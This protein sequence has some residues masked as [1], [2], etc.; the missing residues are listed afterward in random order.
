M[1]GSWLLATSGGM[2]LKFDL[3]KAERVFVVGG[4]KPTAAM[5]LAVEQII[6]HRITDGVISIRE[7]FSVPLQKAR[8]IEASHPPPTNAALL[9]LGISRISSARRVNAI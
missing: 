7:G 5:A 1:D 9:R 8:I 4:G 6:A 2:E 3:S